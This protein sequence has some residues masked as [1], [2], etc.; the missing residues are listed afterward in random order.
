MLVK[1]DFI[2]AGVKLALIEL[3]QSG[4]TTCCDMYFYNQTIAETV[5]SEAGL[6]AYVG[7]GIP[8][9]EKDWPEWKQKSLALRV[10]VCKKS[11]GLKS[12]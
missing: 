6:R 12:L 5:D 2:R 4:I 10:K 7:L 9:V 1:E 8:S 3:I 11:I